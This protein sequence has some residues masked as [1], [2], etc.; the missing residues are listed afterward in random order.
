MWFVSFDLYDARPL[1]G[2]DMGLLD[3]G[4][5]APRGPER[6]EDAGHRWLRTTLLSRARAA[7]RGAV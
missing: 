4:E 1:S 2:P 6:R 5:L 3:F 7:P